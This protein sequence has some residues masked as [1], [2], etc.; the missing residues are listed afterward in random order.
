[1]TRVV[2]EPGRLR[3]SHG[4][5][6]PRARSRDLAASEIASLE[7]KVSMQAGSRSYYDIEAILKDGRKHTIGRMIRK[8]RHAEWLLARI[9]EA[10]AR[11]EG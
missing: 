9:R 4:Y 6:T 7:L 2:V 10:L 3:I 11:S 8:R 1:M 5:V